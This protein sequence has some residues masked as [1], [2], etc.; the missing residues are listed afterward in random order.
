[1]Y[2]Y[3]GIGS[4]KAPKDVLRTFVILGKALAKHGFVLRSGHAPGCDLA[5]EY[6]CDLLNGYK[7]IYIPWKGFNTSD[8]L[9]CTQTDKAIE[10][11]KKYHPSWNGLSQGAKKLQSRNSHQVFGLNMET[12]T[13]FIIC[14][15]KDGKRGGGTGQALR[16]AEANGIK[17]FDAGA[18]KDLNVFVS[19]IKQYLYDNS[20]IV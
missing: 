4:R 16:I 14:W 13:H 11:A 19:D 5:F 2:I 6:G 3:T 17:I 15:T 9:L 7:E 18:Y 10:I 12:P 20:M 1:M 8:S